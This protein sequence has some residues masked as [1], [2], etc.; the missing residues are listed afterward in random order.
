MKQKTDSLTVFYDGACSVCR[1]EIERFRRRDKAGLLTLIDIAAP[2][3]DPA[4][5]GLELQ[6]FMKKLHVRD[7]AGNFHTGVDALTRLWAIMP[8]PELHLLFRG[9]V[10][11]EKGIH[12]YRP[13]SKHY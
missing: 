5:Y 8:Q 13:V 11:P 4:Q 6:V 10:G 2:T 7:A 3:F 1:R 9:Q 12:G